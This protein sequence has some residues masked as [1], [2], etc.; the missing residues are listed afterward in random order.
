M[1]ALAVEC[2]T[3]THIEIECETSVEDTQ[4]FEEKTEECEVEIPNP[5]KKEKKKPKEIFNEEEIS[6][7]ARDYVA[8]P[9][10]EKY[11][12]VAERCIP[13]MDYII[14]EFDLRN[15]YCDSNDLRNELMVKMPHYFNDFAQKRGRL[16][17]YLSTCFK[18]YLN[19]YTTKLATRRFYNLPDNSEDIFKYDDIND[20]GIDYAPELMR[21][22]KKMSIRNIDYTT[23]RVYRYYA[24]AVR[25]GFIDKKN[26]CVKTVSLMYDISK[27]TC[28]FLYNTFMYELRSS[29]L[30][31]HI[32]KISVMDLHKVTEVHSLIPELIEC[33][34][35]ENVEK[36]ITLF[37]GMS[38]KIPR[39]E[40]VKKMEVDLAIYKSLHEDYSEENIAR[41]SR[42]TGIQKAKVRK[43]YDSMSK[44][45][46]KISNKKASIT[47]NEGAQYEKVRSN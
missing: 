2:E 47:I 23:I 36:V 9:T 41:L 39:I 13:L 35:E 10:I 31:A 30:D 5:I 8:D 22:V 15:V 34:G 17:S 29:I 19:S 45:M 3:E 26:G 25:E 16:F 32:E 33:I 42:V 37:G 21:Y 6:K 18:N 20:E 14:S 11:Q 27:D 1:E 38:I 40:N 7:L 28:E 24:D 43:V 44:T 46:Q 4:L 12:Y